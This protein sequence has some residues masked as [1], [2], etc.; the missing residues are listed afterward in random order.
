M[1]NVQ[2]TPHERMGPEGTMNCYLSALQQGDIASAFKF[3]SRTEHHRERALQR[4]TAQLESPLFRPL[5][6][7]LSS[8][9]CYFC[10]F[11]SITLSGI[12]ASP[13]AASVDWH[14][15]RIPRFSICSCPLRSSVVYTL[16]HAENVMTPICD[17]T[18][19]LFGGCTGP[20]VSTKRQ[21]KGL[22]CD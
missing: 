14:C 15:C 8:K 4:Y 3:V 16:V 13:L 5:I 10:S 7:H 1:V 2:D 17:C 20:D 18:E 11:C 12:G 22:R 19:S 21:A 9:V 6:S